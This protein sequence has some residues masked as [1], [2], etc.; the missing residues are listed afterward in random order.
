LGVCRALRCHQ[1][2]R[3]GRRS[4]RSQRSL[5]MMELY[6]YVVY[7]FFF[8]MFGSQ[9]RSRRRFWCT[10]GGSDKVGL[11]KFLSPKIKFSY[12]VLF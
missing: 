1:E 4:L 11:V 8:F 10:L 7:V 3:R 2:E 6:R 12:F 5:L 9:L